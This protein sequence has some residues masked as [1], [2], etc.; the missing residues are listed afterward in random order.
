MED[1]SQGNVFLETAGAAPL[2]VDVLDPAGR[3]LRQ[4]K[5]EPDQSLTRIDLSGLPPASYLM[6]ITSD[7]GIYNEWILVH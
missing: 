4:V 3:V 6:R 7:Q 2:R 5:P 1:L